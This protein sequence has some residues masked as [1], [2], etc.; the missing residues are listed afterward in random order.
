MSEIPR[1]VA[2]GTVYSWFWCISLLPAE[3]WNLAAEHTMAQNGISVSDYNYL[4]KEAEERKEEVEEEVVEEK[5]TSVKEEK[6][7]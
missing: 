2:I 6:N 7:K 5:A 3:D 4:I 1:D